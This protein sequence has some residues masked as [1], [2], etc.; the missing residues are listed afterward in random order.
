MMMMMM[1]MMTM[2]PTCHVSISFQTIKVDNKNGTPPKKSPKTPNLQ[3]FN[4]RILGCLG[5]D[6]GLHKA[7]LDQLPSGTSSELLGKTAVQ[8]V[9]KGMQ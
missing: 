9:G 1:M 3:M 8:Q 7:T 4:W 6:L 2:Y 5:N